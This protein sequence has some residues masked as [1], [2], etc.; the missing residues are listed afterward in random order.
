LFP[1]KCLD[2][3]LK[4]N[5][6]HSAAV[7]AHRRGHQRAATPPRA[8][9]FMQA[10]QYPIHNNDDLGRLLQALPVTP[11]DLPTELVQPLARLLPRPYRAETLTR[12]VLPSLLLDLSICESVFTSPDLTKFQVDELI[13]TMAGE[14]ETFV[15]TPAHDAPPLGR[16]LMLTRIL[17]RSSLLYSLLVRPL[18]AGE[19][20]QLYRNICAAVLRR[21][22][23]TPSPPIDPRAISESA[24]DYPLCTFLL[25]QVLDPGHPLA[26]IT[27]WG[28][29]GTL[30]EWPE[31]VSLTP[32]T[33]IHQDAPFPS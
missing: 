18:S 2:H 4:H 27:R 25:S 32:R 29:S 31:S 21:S 17:L 24:L 10:Q 7:L 14:R 19:A 8:D 6:L 1:E 16:L 15:T 22:P 20:A 30:A 28:S 26:S 3:F 12:C 11:A 33:C 5:D 9:P 13:K 23:H